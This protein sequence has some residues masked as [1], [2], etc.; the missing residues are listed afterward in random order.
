MEV[1][2]NETKSTSQSCCV[3]MIHETE[4]PEFPDIHLQEIAV[5]KEFL[6]LLYDTGRIWETGR[7]F[8]LNIKDLIRT[9]ICP[10]NGHVDAFCTY[11]KGII[12]ATT[13]GELWFCTP[14]RGSELLSS[15]P[16]PGLHAEEYKIKTAFTGYL[17]VKDRI[18]RIIPGNESVCLITTS[19]L[20]TYDLSDGL[21]RTTPLQQ[22]LMKGIQNAAVFTRSG[23]FLYSG[24][25]F[26][27]FGGDLVRINTA[28]GETT[29]LLHGKPVTGVI[30]DPLDTKNVLFSIGLWH[31]GIVKGGIYRIH[32]EEIE[33]VLEGEPVFD[34]KSKGDVF[35]GA[36]L[37]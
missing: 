13:S 15:I 11:E 26:G 25:N 10:D 27:E 34:L 19:S 23:S 2:Q 37:R 32:G 8:S 29:R 35:W 14:I 22:Y 1:K 4:I 30:V 16:I 24:A 7:L 31:L 3:N 12:L 17:P 36:T 33:P 28:S 18:I 5:H 9:E 21:W 20:L 6:W